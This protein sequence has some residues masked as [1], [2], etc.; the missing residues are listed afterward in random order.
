[1]SNEPKQPKKK[2]KGALALIL[3]LVVILAVIGVMVAG[4]LFDGS[5]SAQESTTPALSAEEEAEA[6]A[7]EEETE[8]EEEDLVAEGSGSEDFVIFGV[9]TRSTNL[10]SGT[11][12]DS[13]M[14]VHVDHDA[15]T[16]KVAS[17][18]R[19]CMVHIE[20]HGYEKITHAHSYG[21]PELAVS[22]INENFDLNIEKY[23]TLNFIN[24]ADLIDEIGGVTIEITDEEVSHL[25][26]IDGTYS[27]YI[28]SAGT[29]LL[30]GTQAVKYSRIRYATGGDYKRSERQRTVL[31]NLF[32][33][34]KGLSFTERISLAESMLSQINSNYSTDE[35]TS[36]LYYLSK[37]EITDMTAFP[38]VFYG[39]KVD[40]AWVEVPVSLITM[41]EGLHEFLYGET[42]YEASETVQ[43]YSSYLA[44]K[45]STATYD[46]TDSE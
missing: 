35:I 8:E 45:A 16:V 36:L 46:F 37:Y 9:D 13:I 27:G 23:M 18:Y 28:T 38:Q 44:T 43:S 26:S 6:E 20:G 24:V 40:G 25:S 15:K 17:I 39:G 2:S 11:R 32:E 4:K 3:I 29:Y 7:E 10:G 42:D 31:F 21:G 34:A 30:D 41:N 33:K 5:Q 19:D 12:S 22:T 1:M 14:I